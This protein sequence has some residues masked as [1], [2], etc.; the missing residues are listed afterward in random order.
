MTAV[1]DLRQRLATAGRVPR[2]RRRWAWTRIGA[3]CVLATSAAVIPLVRLSSL[4]E[5]AGIVGR[6]M[7]FLRTDSRAEVIDLALTVSLVSLS[8]LLLLRSHRI[9]EARGRQL[10]RKAIE[11]DNFRRAFEDQQISAFLDADGRILQANAELVNTTGYPLGHLLGSHF[12][13]YLVSPLGEVMQLSGWRKLFRGQGCGAVAAIRAADGQG[14]WLRCSIIPALNQYGR[15]AGYTVLA[16]D[17]TAQHTAL[18]RRQMASALD[19]MDERI[20]VLDPT[21]FDVIFAN[22]AERAARARSLPVAPTAR[23]FLGPAQVQRLTDAARRARN[24]DDRRCSYEEPGPANTVDEVFVQHVEPDEEPPMLVV[25]RRD[26]TDRRAADRAK[27]EFISTVSHELRT[28]LT[29]IKGALG[30]AAAGKLGTMPENA[31]RLL[32]IADNNCDRL[33]RLINDIL[34]IEKIEAGRL[35]LNLEP[36]DLRA[37]VR[38]SCA[39]NAALAGQHGVTLVQ[40]LGRRRQQVAIRADRDRVLQV[41]DNL[42]SNAVKFSERGGSV[43]VALRPRGTEAILRVTDHG[44]G[45]P[46][47]EHARVFEKFTQADSSDTRKRGGTGL[48]LAI[49]RQIVEELGG[50][51]TLDSEIG[52]GTTF[53]VR[54]PLIR[55]GA[56]DERGIPADR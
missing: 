43:E 42:L 26:V 31:V 5:P 44:A 18:A 12:G 41:M 23:D 17:M 4:P 49:T 46:A 54:L 16:I 51:I 50:E 6:I 22:R 9:A 32:K 7:A 40:D 24:L 45:I 10:E 19:L 53:E 48:G 35:V 8:L 25:I 20:L 55:T 13:D 11:A 36:I 52:R 30:L 28:P 14:R 39:A 21:S 15:I 38:Q 2:A 29:S 47:H 37:V 33:I 27:A 34:D 1:P 56:T 3:V